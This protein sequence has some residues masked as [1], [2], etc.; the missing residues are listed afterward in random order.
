VLAQG[1]G[2]TLMGPG[3]PELLGASATQISCGHCQ[4]QLKWPRPAEGHRPGSPGCTS[5]TGIPGITPMGH[6]D[7]HGSLLHPPR[8][9]DVPQGGGDPCVPSRK[10]QTAAPGCTGSSVVASRA[11]RTLQRRDGARAE[12][13]RRCSFN[14]ICRRSQHE[15]SS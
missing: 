8:A 1:W 13:G 6:H 2:G 11:G 14:G 7:P 9:L 3:H 10:G 4:K 12:A 15:S 5:P